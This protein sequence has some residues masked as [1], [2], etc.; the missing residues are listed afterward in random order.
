M[1]GFVFGTAPYQAIILHF[2][3]NTNGSMPHQF[4]F[5]ANWG[6]IDTD[7]YYLPLIT[8]SAVSI[9]CVVTMLVAIDCVFYTCCGHACGLFAALG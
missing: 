5:P 7:K 4:L 1:S 8:L 3:L 2:V 6:P 9:Y